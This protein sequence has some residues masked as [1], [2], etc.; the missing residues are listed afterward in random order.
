MQSSDTTGHAHSAV[1]EAQY[2]EWRERMQARVTAAMKQGL[3]IFQLNIPKG[4][5]F[6][7]YLA[8]IPAADRQYHNC[9]ACRMFLNRFGDLVVIDDKY[10]RVPLLWEYF[11]TPAY[12]GDSA[13]NMIVEMNKHEIST[14]FVSGDFEWGLDRTGDWTHFAVRPLPAYVFQDRL[15][16]PNQ[17][18]AEHKEHFGIIQRALR[19]WPVHVVRQGLEL[20][21]SEA[22]YRGEAVL[23]PVEWF[24]KL[25]TEYESTKDR[26]KQKHILWQF[27]AKAPAAF[28]HIRGSMAA[29]LLDD[30]ASG[31]D[32]DIVKRRFA[33]KMHPLQY[34]RPQAAPTE[35]NI[36]R[37]E[38]IVEK[39]GIANSL[40]RRF[41][42]IEDVRVALWT[43]KHVKIEHERPT[44]GVFSHL[45]PDKTEPVRTAAADM[46]PVKITWEKFKRTVLPNAVDMEVYIRINDDFAALVTA[47]DMDAPPILQWDSPEERN[48]VSW[49]AWVGGSP[50]T[51]W[52]LHG[53]QF[54]PV[55]MVTP[56]PCEWFSDK[57]THHGKGLLFIIEGAKESRR[58]GLALFPQF[59]RAEL[60][61]IRATIEAFSQAGV[62][63][64]GDEPMACGVAFTEGSNRTVRVRTELGTTVYN[65]DRWD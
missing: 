23:P 39:L 58:A 52:G 18:M 43:R 5:L 3:P 9:N 54:V 47:A 49:Y 7:A 46:T 33:D 21:R 32:F 28:C 8:G 50:A 45:L 56:R 42:K 44:G 15:K 14:V 57:F 55:H 41:A 36:K 38:E 26:N 6:E 48:P 34:Q 2:E 53:E 35:Q 60:R 62:L 25:Q 30:I 19:D 40:K 64:G 13:R 1:H 31:M 24:N 65:I 22:L 37:G 61:E 10:E 16:T 59:M 4:A 63:E 51:Q 20:L 27:V 29:T 17:K 11:E 12:Y